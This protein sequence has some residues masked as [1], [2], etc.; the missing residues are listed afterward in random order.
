MTLGLYRLSAL[1]QALGLTA[2]PV[3]LPVGVTG[4]PASVVINTPPCLNPSV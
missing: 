2:N 3:D 4:D 1:S